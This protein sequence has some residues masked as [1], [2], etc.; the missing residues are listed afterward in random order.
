MFEF[1]KSRLARGQI[2][3]DIGIGVHFGACMFGTI[4][5]QD[6]L[7]VTVISDTVNTVCSVVF[8]F[9]CFFLLLFF[10]YDL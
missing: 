7:Q 5:T 4:G 1:N 8:L 2:S 10:F 6:R 9:V 3:V